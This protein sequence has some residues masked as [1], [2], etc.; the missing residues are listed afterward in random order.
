MIRKNKPIIHS[1]TSQISDWRG[2]YVTVCGTLNSTPLMLVILNG[3]NIDDLLFFRNFYNAISNLSDSIVIMGCD[4]NYFLDAFLDKHHSQTGMCRN[5]GL[6]NLMQ[7]YNLVDIWR[8]LHPTTKDFSYFSAVDKSYFFLID[9]KLLHSVID[10]TY[11]NILI[12]DQ[13]PVSLHLDLIQKRDENSCRLINALL[14][15]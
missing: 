1:Q 9:S 12:S 4:F 2:T 11:H 3:P 15:N 8:L 14:K 5:S 13:T 7:S 10:C 6:F